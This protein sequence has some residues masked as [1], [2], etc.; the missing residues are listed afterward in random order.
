[1]SLQHSRRLSMTHTGPLG[2]GVSH[3]LII[4][5]LTYLK[6]ITPSGRKECQGCKLISTIRSVRSDLMS[7]MHHHSSN[8]GIRCCILEMSCMHDLG[9]RHSSGLAFR[10]RRGAAQLISCMPA[11]ELNSATSYLNASVTFQVP[12]GHTT[13]TK[14]DLTS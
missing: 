1:M 10:G 6:R 4:R 5:H 3:V 2:D 9:S 11:T 7:Q 14:G 13:L 12:S 8:R